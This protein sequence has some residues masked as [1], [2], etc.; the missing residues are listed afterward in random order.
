MLSFAIFLMNFIVVQFS[1]K[2]ALPDLRGGLRYSLDS[3]DRAAALQ[4]LQA[5]VAGGFDVLVEDDLADGAVAD[6]AGTRVLDRRDVTLDGG[7]DG[8]IFKGKVG[9]GSH[10]AVLKDEVV[11]VAERLGLGDVAADKA[12][13][14][15]VP[16]K[17]FTV[18]DGVDHGDVLRLPEGVLGVQDAIA[19]L[20]VLGVL[21]AVV[22][23]QFD[24]R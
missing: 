14:L 20:D 18:D 9:V 13:V 22:A 2:K 21:E 16:G 24:V 5:T 3:G 15:R 10:C 17:I 4:R 6:E 7:L 8:G 19:D 11:A 23:V 12:E 1:D